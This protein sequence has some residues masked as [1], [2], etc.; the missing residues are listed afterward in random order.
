MKNQ[1]CAPLLRSGVLNLLAFCAVLFSPLALPAEDL[2]SEGS[3]LPTWK[4]LNSESKQQFISG[5]I[6]GWRDAQRVTEI[7]TSYVKENPSKALDGLQKIQSLYDLGGIKPETMVK[8]IDAFYSST[9]NRRATLSQAVNAAKVA[10][11]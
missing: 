9:E 4:L 11:R 2:S 1:I 10:L 5:Y 7:A 8:A 6:Q 3:F